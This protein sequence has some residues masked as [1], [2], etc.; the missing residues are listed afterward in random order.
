M[1]TL[2]ILACVAMLPTLGLIYIVGF[3]GEQVQTLNEAFPDSPFN[4]DLFGSVHVSYAA[5]MSSFLE[6]SDYADIHPAFEQITL[7]A[8]SNSSGLYDIWMVKASALTVPE[9]LFAQENSQ[10]VENMKQYGL[11]PA[12]LRELLAIGW[13][14]PDWQKS[15]TLISYDSSI[16]GYYPVLDVQNHG[17]RLAKVQP[18]EVRSDFMVPFIKDEPAQY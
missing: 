12:T 13:Y 9:K 17:R 11:H 15:H 1:K 16:T 18:H 14:L 3:S 2:I 4:Y 8:D 7:P 5:P 10:I 6:N